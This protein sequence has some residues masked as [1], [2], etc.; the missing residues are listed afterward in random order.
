[1]RLYHFTCSHALPHIMREGVLKPNAHPMFHA[2]VPAVVWLSDLAEPLRD[3]LGLTSAFLTC[4]RTERRLEVDVEAEPWHLFARRFQIERVV[5]DTLEEF[6]MPMH[7]WVA[8]EPVPVLVGAGVH[9]RET[10]A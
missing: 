8:T 4:D 2:S 1:M 6:G 7:W 9:F 10:E 3:A 5:R